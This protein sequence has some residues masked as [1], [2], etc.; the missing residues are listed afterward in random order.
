MHPFVGFGRH[1]GMQ[2]ETGHLAQRVCELILWIAGRQ[3]LQRKDLAALLR[4]YGDAV[5]NGMTQQL[6]RVL[7]HPIRG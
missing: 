7:I 5:G 4:T 6:H 2:R 3:G 1:A